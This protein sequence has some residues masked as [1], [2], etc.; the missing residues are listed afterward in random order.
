MTG[1][2]EPSRRMSGSVEGEFGTWDDELE[3]LG[4]AFAALTVSDLARAF[5]VRCVA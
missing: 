4:G 1:E 3:W 2:L 5:A